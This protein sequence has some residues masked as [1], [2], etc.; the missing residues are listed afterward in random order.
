MKSLFSIVIVQSRP[1]KNVINIT[2]FELMW[3]RKDFV[4]DIYGTQNTR[5]FFLQQLIDEMKSDEESVV[6]E[7]E[8]LDELPVKQKLQLADV[9]AELPNVIHKQFNYTDY[10][11]LDGSNDRFMR[12][13]RN[14][15]KST[16]FLQMQQAKS[17]LEEKLNNI[18][19]NESTLF[20]Q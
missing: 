14:T 19:T 2:P 6:D 16:E 11:Q 8:V 7:K 20:S 5:E 13:Q 9:E 1:K 3:D 12:K 10:S 17:D 15:D 4:D 18:E